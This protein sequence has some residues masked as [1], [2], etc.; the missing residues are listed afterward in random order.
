MSVQGVKDGFN[1]Y[2]MAILK[3]SLMSFV[4]GAT[5]FQTSMNG[6]KWEFLSGMDRFYIILG[7]AIV[8]ANVLIAFIDKEMAT[9]SANQKILATDLEPT[10]PTPIPPAASS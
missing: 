4:A 5:T 9:I 1:I 8:I 6:L 3:V 2:K 10:T 7:V